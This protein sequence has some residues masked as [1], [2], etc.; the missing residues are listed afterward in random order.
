MSK[1]V[2]TA[3]VLRSDLISGDLETLCVEIIHVKAYNQ[4]LVRIAQL[5]LRKASFNFQM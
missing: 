1:L 5:F 3:F 2:S 4:N